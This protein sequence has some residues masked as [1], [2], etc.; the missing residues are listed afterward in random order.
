MAIA[1][2][3]FELQEIDLQIESREKAVW[4]MTAELGGSDVLRNTR[5]KFSEEQARFDS[6]AAEQRALDWEIDDLSAKLKTIE[7]DLYSGRIKI[8]K[9]LTS[10]QQEIATIK[11]RR[12]Q[13]EDKALIMMEQI[14]TNRKSLAKTTADFKQIETDWKLRQDELNRKIEV[15]KQSITQ[16]TM[17][18]EALVRAIEPAIM[19]TYQTLR[20]QRGSAVAKVEQG[21]CRGCRI[22]LPAGELQNVRSG[23]LVQCS[24]CGRILYFP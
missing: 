23:R 9:E 3:L 15:E 1:K 13:L 21:I 8:P 2:Q 22:A 19:Q 20:K 6:L 17:Q 10:L 14:E 16:L 12:S 7:K 11:A 24:S 4:Q 18:R 5:S